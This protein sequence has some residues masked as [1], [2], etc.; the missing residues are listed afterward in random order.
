VLQA[1]ALLDRAMCEP[2]PYEAMEG[3]LLAELYALRAEMRDLREP[4]AALPAVIRR[5][6]WT[7]L[8]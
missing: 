5:T 7:R 1:L 6:V 2:R 3:R 8:S 4:I